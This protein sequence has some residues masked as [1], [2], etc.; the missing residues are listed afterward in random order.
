MAT[1][2]PE[3]RDRLTR[4]VLSSIQDRE[5]EAR[6]RNSLPTVELKREQAEERI[7][8]RALGEPTTDI[9]I[10]NQQI[11]MERAATR[12]LGSKRTARGQVSMIGTPPESPER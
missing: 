11:Q 8:R 5:A 2:T 6:R 4:S 3:D 1:G 9:D 10:R 7:S 12:G